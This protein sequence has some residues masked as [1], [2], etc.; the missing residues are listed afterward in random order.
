MNAKP[1]SPRRRQVALWGFHAYGSFGDDLAAAVLAAH[2]RE[3]H[4]AHIVAHRLCE[5]YARRFGIRVAENVDDLVEGSDAIVFAGGS[6]LES[7]PPPGSRHVGMGANLGGHAGDSARIVNLAVE[8]HIPIVGISIGGDGMYPRR[9]F[10]PSKEAFLQEARYISVRYRDD[11]LLLEQRGKKGAAFPDILWQAPSLV[12]ASR[13]ADARL[14][15]GIS[16]YAGQLLP[17]RAFWVPPLLYSAALARRDVDFIF[18]DSANASRSRFRALPR[19]PGIRGQHRSFHDPDDDLR[20]LASLDLIIATHVPVGIVAMSYG[21]PFFSVAPE[22]RARRLMRDLGLPHL[23][24]SG[25][26]ASRLW[27]LLK[28]RGG[29]RRFLDGHRVPQLEDLRQQSSGHLD[30]LSQELF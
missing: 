24:F 25:R 6:T 9:L 7:G 17:E 19:I 13:P 1:D 26:D 4:G 22:Q 5:P 12:P 27:S 21:V 2:L 20:F 8:R 3:R 23:C 15:I 28:D 14:R 11:V 10:P 29:L 16:V 18:I 30:A